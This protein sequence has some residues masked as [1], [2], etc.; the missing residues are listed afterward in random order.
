MNKIRLWNFHCIAEP[1]AMVL[2]QRHSATTSP[3][4]FHLLPSDKQIIW[5]ALYCLVNMLNA[6]AL[7][8]IGG[9]ITP[10]NRAQLQVNY[11]QWISI[12]ASFFTLVFYFLLLYFN[13]LPRIC[14]TSREN[15]WQKRA[16]ISFTI[17][18]IFNGPVWHGATIPMTLASPSLF[19]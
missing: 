3:S 11:M 13:M 4:S 10:M 9:K 15:I 8:F 16:T 6:I 14:F 1:I 19:Y 18:C 17:V 5:Y 12:P 7:L 2:I